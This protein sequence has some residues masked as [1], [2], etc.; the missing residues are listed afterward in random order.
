MDIQTIRGGGGSASSLRDGRDLTT[1]DLQTIRKAIC[2]NRG[3]HEQTG[4]A[5]IMTLWNALLP[6]TQ[7]QYLESIEESPRRRKDTKE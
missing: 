7:K 1:I 3:G 5:G 6:E 4:D 2:N